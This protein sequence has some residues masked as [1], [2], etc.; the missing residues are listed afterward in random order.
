MNEEREAISLTKTSTFVARLN[1]AMKKNGIS[2]V[3]LSKLSGISRTSLNNYCVGFRKEP[4]L[5]RK[6]VIAN[7]LGVSLAWLD[8]YDVEEQPIIKTKYFDET[9]KASKVDA[10]LGY[11]SLRELFEKCRNLEESDIQKIIKFI[12]SFIAK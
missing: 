3:K 8:G 6:Q 7:A 11:G 5:A 1:L 9:K 2:Q 10:V 4:S 12:D